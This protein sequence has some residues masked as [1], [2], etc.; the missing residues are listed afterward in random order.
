MKWF[1]RK[2]LELMRQWYRFWTETNTFVQQAA[3]QIPWV[4]NFGI[5]RWR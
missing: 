1:F 4:N 5:G 2:N 3:A